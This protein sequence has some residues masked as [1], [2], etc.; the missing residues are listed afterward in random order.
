MPKLDFVMCGKTT[1]GKRTWWRE[2]PA[3]EEAVLLVQDDF[4]A[5]CYAGKILDIPD[6]AQRSSRLREAFS[7]YIGA[8]FDNGASVTLDFP[9]NSKKPRSSASFK[10]DSPTD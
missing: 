8:L 1:L 7:P 4:L 10:Q 3:R 6:L 5:A 9:V 2:L